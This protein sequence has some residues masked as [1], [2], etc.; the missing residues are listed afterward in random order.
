MHKQSLAITHNAKF[1]ADGGC[2]E[3][4]LLRGVLSF[5]GLN[6]HALAETLKTLVSFLTSQHAV[7]HLDLNVF[8]VSFFT[9][10][11]DVV[12]FCRK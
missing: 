6:G 10:L 12:D 1:H 2:C 4:N 8:T 7:I 11:R 5:I 3:P 9:R